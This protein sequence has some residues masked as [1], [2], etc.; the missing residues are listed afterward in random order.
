MAANEELVEAVAQAIHGAEVGWRSAL[1]TNTPKRIMVARA[2]LAVPAI[3]DALAG[4]HAV[5]SDEGTSYCPLAEANA[6]AVARDAKVAEIV[7]RWNDDA[8][9]LPT[10]LMNRIAALYPE[11][12]KPADPPTVLDDDGEPRQTIT[13]TEHGD[14]FIGPQTPGTPVGYIDPRG[15]AAVADALADVEVYRTALGL[16]CSDGWSDGA[17]AMQSYIETARDHIAALRA[18]DDSDIVP[19]SE[20]DGP[21]IL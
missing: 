14:V 1:G 2:V 20:F 9:L 5:T 11:T 8:G 4:C 15:R 21:V 17:S 7:G 13:L 12:G 16:A 3:A 10:S 19:G 18:V 6:A